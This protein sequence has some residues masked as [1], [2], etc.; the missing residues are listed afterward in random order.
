[1][2]MREQQFDAQALMARAT[3]LAQEVRKSEAYPALIGGI[4]GG[5]AGGLIAALIAGRVA[6]SR[7][8][9]AS[10]ET[11]SV[12]KESGGGWNVRDLVQLTTVVAALARQV[13]AWYQEQKQA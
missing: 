10:F 5:I 11:N 7:G 4:A 2:E 3:V 6:S 12:K 1:M 13:Q 9:G 8:G